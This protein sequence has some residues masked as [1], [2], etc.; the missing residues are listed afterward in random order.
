MTLRRLLVV[1]LAALA[2]TAGLTA[3]ETSGKFVEYDKGKKELTVEVNGAK[4][5]F[6]LTDD[7]KVVTARGESA[8]KG[9]ECFSNPRVA[10]PGAPLTVVTTPK[11]GKDVV[12]EIKLGGKAK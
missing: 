5:K 11:D 10:R 6:T 8:R 7:V 9:L 3:G 1:L 2:C 4:S 12:T